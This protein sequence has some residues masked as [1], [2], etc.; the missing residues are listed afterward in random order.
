[1]KAIF[2]E[3]NIYK[4]IDLDYNGNLEICNTSDALSSQIS[5]HIGVAYTT[6]YTQLNAST[7]LLAVFTSKFGKRSVFIEINN[8]K[9]NQRHLTIKDIE[10]YIK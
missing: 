4:V 6:L 3:G 8:P 9:E 2:K 1:M 7:P 10:N 5:S